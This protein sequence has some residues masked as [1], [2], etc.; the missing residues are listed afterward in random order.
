[1][2]DVKCF[3]GKYKL[4]KENLKKITVNDKVINKIVSDVNNRSNFK[5]ERTING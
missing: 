5:M 1:M 3:I 4:D 2:L